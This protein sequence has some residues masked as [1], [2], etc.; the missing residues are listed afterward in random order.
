MIYVEFDQ[1]GRVTLLHYMPFDPME[2]ITN[3]EGNI[4]TPE[5]LTAKGG[6]LVTAIPTAVQQEG[7][8][9]ELRVNLDSKELYYVYEDAPLTPEQELAQL[10]EKQ[11]LMQKVLDDLLLGG[12]L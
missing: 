3:A 11:T 5:E 10:K 8:N 1:D 4:C 12:A 9:S 6:L 2:G 7:K